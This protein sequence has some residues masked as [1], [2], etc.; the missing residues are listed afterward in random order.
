MMM[1]LYIHMFYTKLVLTDSPV[2][3]SNADASFDQSTRMQKSFEK[4]FNPVMLVFIG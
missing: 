2:N 4:S 3:P 1:Y